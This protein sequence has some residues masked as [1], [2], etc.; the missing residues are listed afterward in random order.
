MLWLVRCSLFLIV[1]WSLSWS[2]RCQVMVLWLPFFDVYIPTCYYCYVTITMTM[3]NPFVFHVGAV[4]VD[5][6]C[7]CFLFCVSCRCLFVFLIVVVYWLVFRVFFVDCRCV[8]FFV[9]LV[10]VHC[11]LGLLFFIVLCFLSLFIVFC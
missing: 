4:F 10:V 3:F 1:A 5:C 7:R 11:F 6:R 8:F 9:F 2:E